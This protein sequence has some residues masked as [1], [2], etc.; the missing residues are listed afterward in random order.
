MAQSLGPASV[1]VWWR[2]VTERQQVFLRRCILQQPPPWTA[3]PII[4]RGYFTNVYRE[5]DRVTRDVIL[6]VLEPSVG[7][8]WDDRL[9]N[10]LVYRAFNW[11]AT[12]TVLG[13]YRSRTEW[14]KTWRQ[15]ERAALKLQRTTGKVF[16]GAYMINAASRD[17]GRYRGPGSK[18]SLWID[19]LRRAAVRWP[20]I[21]DTIESDVY[22]SAIE[23]L[24]QVEGVAGFTAQEIVQDASYTGAPV[25]PF[26]G[27]MGVVLGP[28]ALLG[29]QALFRPEDRLERI[30]P[31]RGQE[32]I[33][34]LQHQQRRLPAVT[35]RLLRGPQLTLWNIEDTL[36]EFSKYSRIHRGERPKRW[37]KGSETS[38]LSPWD[39]CRDY[40]RKDWTR[41]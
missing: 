24:R 6:R 35:G 16:T 39:T 8:P 26:D 34:V 2:Y 21:C 18:V 9:F 31:A 37:Y 5:T 10:L 13:G 40:W 12:W 19:R 27:S 17:Q 28:G 15:A 11:P 23:A 4:A 33:R 3:D 25:L 30:T 14:K 22:M 41:E 29:A 32:I 38:D 36:C 1:R 20:E 7:E